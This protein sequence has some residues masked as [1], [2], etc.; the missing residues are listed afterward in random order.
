MIKRFSAADISA[1]LGTM[2][3]P[4]HARKRAS[5]WLRANHQ[6]GAQ[7]K[8]HLHWVELRMI[9]AHKSR[10][11]FDSASPVSPERLHIINKLHYLTNRIQGPLQHRRAIHVAQFGVGKNR[12]TI[13]AFEKVRRAQQ[14]NRKRHE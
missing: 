8:R 14:W 1:R 12:T 13:E 10:S 9:E 5:Q 2:A 3:N 7:R 11:M 6:A 4:T